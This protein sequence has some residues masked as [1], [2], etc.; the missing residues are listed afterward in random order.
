MAD[1]IKI[2]VNLDGLFDTLVGTFI[3]IY[4]DKL[5]DLL[6][7]KYLNRT[8]NKL[9]DIVSGVDDDLIKEGY[10]NRD[11]TTLQSSKATNLVKELAV[12]IHKHTS[13]LEED[14]LRADVTLVINTYPYILD[15]A[16]TKEL[17]LA[18]DEAML[19]TTIK[20]V[21]MSLADI[22]P[23]YL[24][25]F[26]FSQF[27]VEDFT[28]WTRGKEQL[29]IETPIPN[30]TIMAPLLVLQTG[31]DAKI[32]D[33]LPQQMLGFWMEFMEVQMTAADLFSI[34]GG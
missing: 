16:T 28:E 4:P 26:T 23:S 5:K 1:E 19:P 14:P 29:V 34:Q 15:K 33:D 8:T 13:V 27:I 9:S 7:P 24:K 25:L 32:L 18:L 31:I 2:L 10:A 20:T 11:L 6:I 21:H 30:I 22:T 17:F 12:F 3:R